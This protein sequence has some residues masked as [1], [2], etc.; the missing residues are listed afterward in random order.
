MN[1]FHVFPSTALAT[2]LLSDLLNPILALSDL[3][4]DYRRG[5]TD[6]LFVKVVLSFGDFVLGAD[7][8]RPRPRTQYFYMKETIAC[9]VRSTSDQ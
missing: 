1:F 2:D 8:D 5:L 3:G 4:I 9:A 6:S 7:R